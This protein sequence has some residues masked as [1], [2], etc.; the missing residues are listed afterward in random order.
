MYSVYDGCAK[1]LRP[2]VCSMYE[3]H[4]QSL[5]LESGSS[6]MGSNEV[7]EGGRARSCRALCTPI[8]VSVIFLK[9]VGNQ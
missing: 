2:E 3:E 6:D 8:R 1:A 7:G 9:A 5:C 4:K